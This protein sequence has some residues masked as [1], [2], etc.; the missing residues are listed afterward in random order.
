MSDRKDSPPPRHAPPAAPVDP[1]QPNTA[2]YMLLKAHPVLPANGIPQ[3]AVIAQAQDFLALLG[4]AAGQGEVLLCSQLVL[5][6][7]NVPAPPKARP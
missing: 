2:F 7:L 1:M 5:A 6:R 3:Y 4:A